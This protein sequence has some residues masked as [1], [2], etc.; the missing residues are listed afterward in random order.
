MKTKIHL[1]VHIAFGI[2]IG[3]ISLLELIYQLTIKNLSIPLQF[4]F[5]GL[6]V[7]LSTTNQTIL[8][9]KLWLGRKNLKNNL[10]IKQ[11]IL[12][13]PAYTIFIVINLFYIFM[14]LF[15]MLAAFFTY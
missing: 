3:V 10:S 14:C 1:M 8:M 13:Y 4:I 5:C 9:T 11:K 6:I 15:F 12:P 7:L 2:L